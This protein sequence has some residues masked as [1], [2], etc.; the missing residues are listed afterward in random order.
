MQ[1][2]IISFVALFVVLSCTYQNNKAE[3]DPFSKKPNVQFAASKHPDRI[4]QS[5]SE[6]PARQINLSWR[7]SSD[8]ET[9]F[10]EY[11][12]LS[13]EITKNTK[14]ETEYAT[15][16]PVTFENT[17]DHYFQAKL[18][19][20][21]PNTSYMM[22]VGSESHRSEWFTTRTAPE[23]FEPYHF[24]Y[25][26]DMQNDILEYGSRTFRK[27]FSSFP[28]SRFMI[29]AGDLVVSSGDD[30]TWGEWFYA[31]NRVFQHIPSLPVAGNSDHYRM[32]ETPVD[33][34]MLFPQW[35][36]IFQLPE[37]GPSGLENLS[38]YVDYPKL[39][40]I[41]LYTNFESA[42][43]DEREIYIDKHTKL[44]DDL[45]QKQLSWMEEVLAE[46]T[47]PWTVVVMHHPVFTAREERNN[48]LL[49]EYF[50]PLFE[51]HQVDLVLQGHDHVYARG[52]NPERR[53]ES[54]QL[55]VYV[56]SISGGKMREVNYDYTW[57]RKA[58][59]NTQIFSVIH[60]ESNSLKLE[61][62]DVTGKLRDSFKIRLTSENEK[63][64]AMN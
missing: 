20:L 3:K 4:L 63:S 28:D 2:T 11:S 9:G 27:A 34:R 48:E 50:L 39:R 10:I 38:Y 22:R 5:V 43:K 18:T 7:S 52:I 42:G 33:K 17:T 26:G 55:P 54:Q 44:T 19:G 51:K 25:F 29:H 57:I 24:L 36:G 46:N 21:Q 56:I 41:A 16:V 13:A 15:V 8:V 58:V 35:N 37:N 59:E 49:Q 62:F 47:Q 45:F 64:L 60:I 6:D 32:Q 12:V 1:K 40:V 23:T 14:V 31:G 53:N 61:S 30:D